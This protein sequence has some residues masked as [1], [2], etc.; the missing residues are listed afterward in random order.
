MAGELK[1]TIRTKFSKVY[2]Y[3]CLCGNKT[4]L[5]EELKQ[6]AIKDEHDILKE[7]FDNR[8]YR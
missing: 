4:K 1:N 3:I 7:E 5:Q 8:K 6:R 2:L